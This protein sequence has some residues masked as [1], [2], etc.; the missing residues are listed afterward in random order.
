MRENIV[1][2]LEIGKIIDLEYLVKKLNEE[3]INYQKNEDNIEIYVDREEVN[4]KYEKVE[5]Y[6]FK[7]EIKIIDIQKKK[8][9]EGLPLQKL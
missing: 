4:I 6:Y 5:S 9:S 8:I 1:K 2:E 7:G 3:E